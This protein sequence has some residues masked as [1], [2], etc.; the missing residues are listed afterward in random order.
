MKA[1][2]E[3]KPEVRIPPLRELMLAVPLG[4]SLENF[5]VINEA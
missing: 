1:R 4:V 3:A 5:I 2:G